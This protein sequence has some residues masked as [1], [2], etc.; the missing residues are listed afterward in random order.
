MVIVNDGFL[1]GF[2]DFS[3]GQRENHAHLGGADGFGKLVRSKSTQKHAEFGLND[4]ENVG[5][6]V[7]VVMEVGLIEWVVAVEGFSTSDGSFH[8]IFE[9]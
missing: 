4:E 9:D 8:H 3:V 6:V 7:E 5:L 2:E 1:I